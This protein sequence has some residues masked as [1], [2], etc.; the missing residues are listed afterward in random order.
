MKIPSPCNCS[1]GCNNKRCSCVNNGVP[2]GKDCQ[3]NGC[4]NPL[5]AIKDYE[6]LT[7]CALHAIIKRRSISKEELAKVHEL[8]CGCETVS[9][10]ELLYLYECQGCEEYYYYSFCW[11]DVVQDGDT[12]HCEICHKCRD[13]REWHCPKCNKCTYGITLPCQRCGYKNKDY[14][15]MPE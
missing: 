9:L 14:A 10:K 5:N 4:A 13:W 15:W 2:C 3:C 11:K 8:P 12:S 6:H 7:A 1:T